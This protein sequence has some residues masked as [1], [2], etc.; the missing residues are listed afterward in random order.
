MPLAPK[1]ACFKYADK[2]VGCKLNSGFKAL[3]GAA[4]A[5]IIGGGGAPSL[6]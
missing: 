2:L 4:G 6:Y 3:L 1:H 5:G